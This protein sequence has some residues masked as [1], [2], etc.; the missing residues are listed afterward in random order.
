MKSNIYRKEF[1][2]LGAAGVGAIGVPTFALPT[3]VKGAS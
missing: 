2:K 3:V 1:L